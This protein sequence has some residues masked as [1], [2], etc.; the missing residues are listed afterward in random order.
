MRFLHVTTFY[1]PYHFGGDAVYVQRLA[2]LLAAAGHE[3]DVVHSLD[4]YRL[5][6]GAARPNS[7]PARV[8]VHRLSSAA[9]R[10]SALVTHQFGHPWP[11]RTQLAPIF[12]RN[13]DVIHYHNISLLGPAV[14][15]Y[16][17]AR[18]VYTT[19]EHWLICPMHVLWQYQRQVCQKPTCLSCVL[20]ARRPPQWWR[21]SS[22]LK[23]CCRHVDLFLAPSEST[24]RRHQAGG[25]QQE[26][27]VLPLF[28]PEPQ[29]GP[30]R[31]GLQ[32]PYFL[33]VGRLERLKGLHT[34][35]PYFEHLEA[36]LVV[37]GDGPQEP[38]LRRLA[39]GNPR[40]H[41]LGWQNSRQ[42]A[43]LYPHARAV[44]VPSLTYETFGTVILEAFS[45]ATPVV[46]SHLAAQAGA[47][48][49]SGG[50]FVYHNC[51]ELTQQLAALT[52]DPQQA[53]LLGNRG[54]EAYRKH[55]T[56][57]QHL[58]QYLGLVS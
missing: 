26:F 54:Y 34:L 20:Q 21:Y 44:V 2:E 4:A 52:L 36:E 10:L 45:Y 43:G 37:A 13:Y 3:V 31:V 30:P 15:G 25:I 39:E 51:G 18:K 27:R 28:S 48:Q 41:F 19:H 56:P 40:V 29:P 46:A 12:A 32:R 14:L 16:G 53:K 47:I 38:E 55:W 49:N 58:K 5:M 8:R 50:G 23:R 7:E 22:W 1:P 57:E 11:Y 17:R 24:V 6:G 35:L 9:P 42:L 33:Y